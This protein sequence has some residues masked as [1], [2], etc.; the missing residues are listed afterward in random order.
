MRKR[1]GKFSFY[2]ILNL[3]SWHKIL[4]LRKRP[5][6]LDAARDPTPKTYIRISRKRERGLGIQRIP[7]RIEVTRCL[8][9]CQQTPSCVCFRIAT[10]GTGICEIFTNTSNPS[11][12]NTIGFVYYAEVS[13]KFFSGHYY[14]VDPL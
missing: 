9:R 14:F 10:T 5:S 11:I 8:G 3:K 2:C 1:V 13:K 4:S 6:V 7:E 12:L